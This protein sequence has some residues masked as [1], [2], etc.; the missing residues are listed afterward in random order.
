MT[1]AHFLLHGCQGATPPSSFSNF[2]FAAV[3]WFDCTAAPLDHQD[4]AHVYL[5]IMKALLAHWSSIL[6]LPICSLGKDAHNATSD[7]CGHGQN[8]QPDQG[9]L[10]QLKYKK[11]MEGLVVAVPECFLPRPFNSYYFP[12]NN[13]NNWFFTWLQ[14]NDSRCDCPECEDEV[15]WDCSSCECPT[16]CDKDASYCVPQDESSSNL[17]PECEK[18]KQIDLDWLPENLVP[19]CTSTTGWVIPSFYVEDGDCSLAWTLT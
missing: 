3:F 2:L 11:E 6:F 16:S 8:C 14:F 9:G 19:A 15:D 7:I 5:R 1:S 12:C 10:L 17:L 4:T 13:S 18:M